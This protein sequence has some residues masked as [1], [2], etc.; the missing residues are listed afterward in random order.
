MGDADP[1]DVRTL[2]HR[3]N[4]LPDDLVDHLKMGFD[5]LSQTSPDR[6]KTLMSAFLST[7]ADGTNVERREGAR[8]LD[9][10]ENVAG[11][12]LAAVSF[13]IGVLSDL[14][15]SADDFVNAATDKVLDDHESLVKELASAIIA[16]RDELKTSSEQREL[17]NSVLP[18]FRG[19]DYE[20]DLRIK[21]TEDNKVSSRVPVLVGWVKT[22]VADDLWLQVTEGNLVK[23]R[24]M[25]N[26]AIERLRA[27]K[28][29]T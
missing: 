25:L 14:E 28:T 15:V 11:D 4:G 18:S 29:V 1:I 17:A 22:D 6:R 24:D 9:V 5:L 13:M 8:I 19:F 23:W 3:I 10:P 2:R 12:A 26:E 27:A 16:E 21:F 7:Y 20:I